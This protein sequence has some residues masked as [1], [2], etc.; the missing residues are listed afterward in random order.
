MK[1]KKKIIFISNIYEISDPFILYGN[2]EGPHSVFVLSNLL[3]DIT[4][5]RWP[6][7]QGLFYHG[8]TW[9]NEEKLCM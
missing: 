2:W 4:N 6:S 3:K 8:T 5:P 7:S 9:E 1:N